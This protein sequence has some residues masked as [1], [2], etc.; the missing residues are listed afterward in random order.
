MLSAARRATTPPFNTP[1]SLIKSEPTDDSTPSA[2]GAPVGA[3]FKDALAAHH[4]RCAAQLAQLAPHGSAALPM[5]AGFKRAAQHDVQQQHKTDDTQHSTGS[6]VP[7]ASLMADNSASS[8]SGLPF[9]VPHPIKGPFAGTVFDP[10]PRPNSAQEA[11]AAGQAGTQQAAVAEPTAEGT[12]DG[13]VAD[14]V[15]PLA[16]KDGVAGVQQA[17]VMAA[18]EDKQAAEQLAA[19]ALQSPKAEPLHHPVSL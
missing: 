10:A 9:A 14:S 15:V 7:L 4:A 3:Q 19:R 18:E 12:A 1:R 16:L 11:R 13:A 8:N 6:L 5:S 2:A 17:A